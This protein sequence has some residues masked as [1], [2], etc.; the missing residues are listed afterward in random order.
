MGDFSFRIRFVRSPR[1]TLNIESTQLE[2]NVKGSPSPIILCSKSE[3]KAIQESNELIL[4]GSGWASEDEAENAGKKYTDA[5]VFS[6]ACL[7]V[8]ADFGVR[9]P[10]SVITN[11]GLAMFE[12]LSG[13]RMLKD[14]Q[15][16]MIYETNPPPLFLSTKAEFLRGIAKD[17]FEKAF[18]YAINNPPNFTDRE[19]LSL[20]LYNASFF[21]ESIDIRFLLLM[22]AIEAILEPSIRSSVSKE[23]VENLIKIT[24]ESATLSQEEKESIN[25][26]LSR[27]YK[28]SIRQTGKKLANERLGSRQYGNQSASS[29][30]SY[31]Y[32]LR[33]KLVHGDFPRPALDDVNKA[34]GALELFVRDLL[35]GPVLDSGIY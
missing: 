30:F 16:T 7:R 2:L 17:S 33:S 3:G 15:G 14:V 32:D 12:N 21:Q 28:E 22:M 31:C 8:G 9:A 18:L 1:H 27:L 29:F 13:R 11:Y 19:R 35:S 4:K 5:L 34:T 10:K 24:L 20:E 23:H 6:L 25:G 26:T